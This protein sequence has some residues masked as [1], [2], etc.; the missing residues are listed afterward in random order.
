MTPGSWMVAIRRIRP[1][2]GGQAGVSRKHL[3][4]YLDEFVFRFNRRRTP[5]TAFQSLLGLTGQHGATT[6]NGLRG[7]QGWVLRLTGDPPQ[8]PV[9]SA[10]PLGSP[11]GESRDGRGDPLAPW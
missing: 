5:M 4:H 11:P 3:P 9:V 6:Y 10:N 7:P 8:D 1:P 2:Q